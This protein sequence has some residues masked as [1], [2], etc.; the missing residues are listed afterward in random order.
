MQEPKLSLKNRINLH[1]LDNKKKNMIR[2]HRLD[3]LVWES[4]L[5]SNFSCNFCNSPSCTQMDQMR[6]DMPLYK[7]F[8]MVDSLP[9]HFLHRTD[10]SHMNIMIA[11]GEPLLR[12]DLEECGRGLYNRNIP[13]GIVTNAIGMSAKR[14]EDLVRVG[15]RTLK[16]QMD[17]EENTVTRIKSDSDSYQNVIHTLKTASKDPG[18]DLEVSTS[19][20]S[21]NVKE[22]HKLKDLLI[23][24][25]VRKWRLFS[26]LNFINFPCKKSLSLTDQEMEFVLDFINEVKEEGILTITFAC[27]SLMGNYEKAI[28]KDFFFCKA[29]ISMATVFVDGSVGI[30]L[31]NRDQ[32]CMLGNIY[33]DNLYELWQKDYRKFLNVDWTKERCASKCNFEYYCAGRE[34]EKRR[35]ISQIKPKHQVTKPSL[36]TTTYKKHCI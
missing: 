36:M 21:M 22:L 5:R 9:H 8:D 23:S 18:I 19:I 11:G 34:K 3:C 15:L 13:W 1:L 2:T 27:D 20:N 29:G 17:T 7:F 31:F 24:C 14:L 10:G 4:T 25:G 33:T 6:T 28:H 26:K 32:D 16:I 35:S 30:C 12:T